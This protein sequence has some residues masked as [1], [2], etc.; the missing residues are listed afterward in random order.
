MRW[1]IRIARIAGTDIKIHLTFLL[2]LAWIGFSYYRQGGTQAAV[3]GVTFILLLFGCVVL[4]ELGHAAAARRF[5]IKTPDI[6]LLPI[7]GVARMQRM[8]DKPWQE[9]IV[10][11]A[12]PAVNVVIAAILIFVL[13]NEA[14]PA[15]FGRIDDPAVP[16]AAKLAS[17]NIMLVVFNMIPAFP[18]DGGRVLRSLLAMSI[19]YSRGT[20]IAASIGQ[21]LAFVFG[22]LGL[23]FNPLLIF[24][25]LFVYLG[26]TQEAALAQM[27]EV[28]TGA[29]VS[30]AMMTRFVTLGPEDTLEKAVNVLL[31]TCQHEFPIVEDGGQ[32]VG[33]L[34]RDDMIKGLREGGPDAPARDSARRDLPV[35][36]ANDN[37]EDAFRTMQECACPALPVLDSTGRLVGLFTPETVGE[38]MMIQSV[39]HKGAS[40]A[41][42]G[43]GRLPQVPGTTS[44]IQQQSQIP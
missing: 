41:W 34:T 11:L 42:H 23:F 13:R 2:L 19:G 20:R 5:G 4:H 37:F 39:L 22:F 16:M 17:V 35:L 36:S 21:V 44:N 10:A 18:M 14:D 32:L 8:P 24:I 27:K 28:T 43:D 6:I 40:P 25:A 30:D 29:H 15:H 9:L 33:V 38:L 7:G 31:Q 1:S 26:A 12:G 3:E